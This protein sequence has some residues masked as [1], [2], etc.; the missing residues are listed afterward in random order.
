MKKVQIVFWSTTGIVSA[1]MLFSGYSYLTSPDIAA[2]FT[3]LG[4][5][6]YFRVELGLAKLI[7]GLILLVPIKH[8]IKGFTYAGFAITFLSASIAHSSSGDPASTIITPLVFLLLLGVSFWSYRKS[9][10]YKNVFVES[11]DRILI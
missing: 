9:H 2:A 8:W 1:M 10:S 11:E 3:H 5:P 7:G 4:F 6:D